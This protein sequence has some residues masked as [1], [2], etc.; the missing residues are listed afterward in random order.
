MQHMTA[1]AHHAG[2]NSRDL[3][4]TGHIRH[5][6]T[7]AEQAAASCWQLKR[8][9]KFNTHTDMWHAASWQQLTP[10]H[11]HRTCGMQQPAAPSVHFASTPA[12][13]DVSYVT[14]LYTPV[15]WHLT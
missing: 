7:V 13:H 2:R 8:S 9:Q 15:A 4:Y 10:S 6:A 5:A 12:T 11:M 14:T 3:T 1:I